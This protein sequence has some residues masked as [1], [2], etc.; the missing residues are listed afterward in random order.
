MSSPDNRKLMG[1]VQ[2]VL[3]VKHYAISTERT[4]SAPLRGSPKDFGTPVAKIDSPHGE[5][6]MPW[7]VLRSSRFRTT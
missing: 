5:S 3:R 1:H 6:I 4:S 2:Q 7:H